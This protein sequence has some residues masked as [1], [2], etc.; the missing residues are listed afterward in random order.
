MTEPEGR[1]DALGRVPYDWKPADGL[2]D[3]EKLEYC[4]LAVRVLDNALLD[5]KVDRPVFDS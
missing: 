1:L 2:N 4:R 5:E 3:P